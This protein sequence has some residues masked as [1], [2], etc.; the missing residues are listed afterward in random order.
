MLVRVLSLQN[1]REDCEGELVQVV[2]AVLKFERRDVLERWRHFDV[3]E[4]NNRSAIYKILM[5]RIYP[6]I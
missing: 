5:G 4:F 3:R 1:D 6:N 2:W